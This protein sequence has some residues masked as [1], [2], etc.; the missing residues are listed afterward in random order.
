MFVWVSVCAERQPLSIENALEY[1]LRPVFEN[2]IIKGLKEKN[3]FF[4]NII[5]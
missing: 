5:S 3:I 2:T 1:L 4:S